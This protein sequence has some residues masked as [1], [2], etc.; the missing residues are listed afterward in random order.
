MCMF[1]TRLSGRI[2]NEICRTTS[3]KEGGN[4]YGKESCKGSQITNS[5]R[6]S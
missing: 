2:L 1:Y 6:Q 4:N 3:L 5:S